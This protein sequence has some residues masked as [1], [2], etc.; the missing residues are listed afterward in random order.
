[1]LLA[2]A[3][4]CDGLAAQVVTPPSPPDRTVRQD[5]TQRDSVA[6][7]DSARRARERARADTIKTPTARAD[8][9]VVPT[10]GPAYAWE[11]DPLSTTGALTLGEL[12][13][14]IP[15]VTTYRSGWIAAPEL[16][17]YLGRLGRVRVF[18][19][20]VELDGLNARMDGQLDL[21]MID[22]WQLEDATIEQ[23]ADEVR[24]HLRTWRV[25]STIP[26]TRIDINTGDLQ[27][28]VFR[29]F[30]GR[31]LPSG[32]VIQVGGNHYSTT[33]RRTDEAGDQT[34]M[35]GRLGWA[36]GKWSV[37]GTFLRS[38]RKFTER[39]LED[40]VSTDTLPTLDGLSAV[41]MARVAWGDPAAGP[42]AQAIVSGQSFSIRNPPGTVVDS[43]EG[44]DGGLIP[45]TNAVS[46][47]TTMARTQ[48]ILTGG[49]SRGPLRLAATARLRRWHGESFL[50]PSLRADYATDRI[51]ASGYAER[52]PIDSIQQI[53]GALRVLLPANLAIGGAV[54]RTNVIENGVGPVTLALRGELG[55]RTGRVWWTAG[56]MTRDTTLLPAAIGFD[57]AYVGGA[58]GPTT[59]YFATIRGKFY[60]D[61]GLDVTAVRYAD[62]GPYRPQIET[63]S[64]LYVDSDMRAKFPS[65]NLNIL[66]AVTHEYRTEAL[67]PTASEVLQSSQYRT[68]GAELEIRLLTATI[69]FLYRNFLGEQ[70]Q[71]VPG[72]TMPSITSYYGIR[73]SFVN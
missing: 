7:T 5:S 56:M 19:D 3:W 58:A 59:G 45:D 57:T 65:G 68:W 10:I 14:R 38:G 70:F 30:Y 36:S 12:V 18:L 20:G 43:I 52:S 24:V 39:S 61:V 66:V 23:G 54:T 48:Y 46:N 64:R 51:I 32:H 63:R 21:S 67:F 35:W 37:D 22:M 9:P 28:N 33:N 13:D 50:A 11:R 34:T 15:G 62:A 44:P 8:V 1:M 6:R 2:A 29:G 25:T 31:R 71:Q 27:T 41:T 53:G 17:A 16:A 40:V 60:R 73:W 72:F 55:V 69:T 49:L 26:T 47:D 42:W 4:P